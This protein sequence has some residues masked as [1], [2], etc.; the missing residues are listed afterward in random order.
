MSEFDEKDMI[1]SFVV[2]APGKCL[3]T[4][5]YLI[6]EPNQKG[7]SVSVDAF[8]QATVKVYSISTNNSVIHVESDDL[9]EKWIYSISDENSIEENE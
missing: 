6:L 1:S 4:G 9:S 2:K 3:L 5:G 8:T 7:L